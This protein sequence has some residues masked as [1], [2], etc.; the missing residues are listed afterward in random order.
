MTV[1]YFLLAI[2]FLVFVH[3]LGHFLAARS[4]GVRVLSFSI[5]FGPA[6]ASL[7]WRGTEYR[8]AMIPL[9]GYVKMLGESSEQ[10][11]NH[12]DSFAAQSP[13]KRAWISFAGPLA[14]LLLAWLLF[15]A[16]VWQQP[17]QLS[18]LIDAPEPSSWAANR[19]LE[20][21]DRVV[22]VGEEKI[23]TWRDLELAL[24]SASSDTIELQFEK[25]GLI[26]LKAGEALVNAAAGSAQDLLNPKTLG[27]RP[28]VIELSVGQVM[29]Q[30]PAEAAGLRAGD[31][32]IRV[33]DQPVR[34]AKVL[35]DLIRRSA[36]QRLRFELDRD[37]ERMRI[38]VVPAIETSDRGLAAAERASNQGQGTARIGAS[39][40]PRFDMVQMPR[41]WYNLIASASIQTWHVTALT[42]SSLW[43]MLTGELSWRQLGGPVSIAD[44]AGQSAQRGAN[45]YLGF[46]AVLSIGLFVLNMI[47]LPMLDGGHLVYCAIEILRGRAL[48]E[49]VRMRLQQLGLTAILALTMIALWNDFSR[50]F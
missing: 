26:E 19:G 15:A 14:N 18:A 46:L 21:G 17:E 32:L 29:P 45:A 11:P 33:N 40:S 10:N 8:L 22:A 5:G 27:L 41:D 6:I 28:M 30:S 3:E 20:A 7:T 4:C 43:R 36:D 44:Q 23:K 48:S 38:D 25:Q 37:G 2:T 13:L 12:S 31:R 16:L 47:P 34:D 24:R 1:V 49:A 50:F 9:G 35:I 42:V 39:L